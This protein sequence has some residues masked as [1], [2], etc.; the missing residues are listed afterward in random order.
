MFVVNLSGRLGNQMFEYAFALAV[1]HKKH[2]S[3]LFDNPKCFILPT[4]FNISKRSVL[5]DKIPMIRI[6]VRRWIQTKRHQYLLDFTNV[7]LPYSSVIDNAYYDGYF[8]SVEWF[9]NIQ[10]SVRKVF[11]IKPC[12]VKLFK[13]KYSQTFA[14]RKILVVHIRRTDYLLHGFGMNFR[15]HDISL[16]MSY[17]ENCFKQIIDFD[18]YLMYVIGDDYEY[19]KKHFAKYT[20]VIFDHNEMILDLQLMMNADVVVMSNSTFAWW[21]AFLNNKKQKKVFAPKCFLGYKEG[22][23]YPQGIYRHTDFT[24]VD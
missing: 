5:Y 14:N 22:F 7:P 3:F 15:Y 2:V 4:F 1:Q 20:N 23:E 10:N 13:K 21:G 9:K 17:Y 6:W 11:L 8:Q 12:Y 16:P 24:I 18:D 19:I